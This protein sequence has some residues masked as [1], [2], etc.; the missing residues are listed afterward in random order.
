MHDP[1]VVEVCYGGE[2]GPYEVRG[3][4]FVVVTFAADAVEKL[5]TEGKVGY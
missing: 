5:P 3:I 2:S 4:G 1:M